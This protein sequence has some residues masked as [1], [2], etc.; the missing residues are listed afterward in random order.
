MLSYLCEDGGFIH[1]VMWRC[2]RCYLC[3]R[4]VC[5]Q[6][7]LSIYLSLLLFGLASPSQIKY[8][9]HIFI[10]FSSKIQNICFSIF[11]SQIIK[12]IQI[13]RLKGDWEASEWTSQRMKKK[14]NNEKTKKVT[15]KIYTKLFMCTLGS[16][17]TIFAAIYYFQRYAIL[18]SVTNRP[19]QTMANNNKNNNNNHHKNKN[20]IQFGHPH[21]VSLSFI[22]PFVVRSPIIV[23]LICVHYKH[24][25]LQMLEKVSKT[26]FRKDYESRHPL[27]MPK[28][29]NDGQKHW[30]SFPL[31]YFFFPP[32][33][34][35]SLPLST[36]CV[37]A[38]VN[39]YA[40][41]QM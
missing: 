6:H 41:A 9:I 3:S 37:P 32:S 2:P 17:H 24:I 14:W 7:H 22:H 19:D 4:S 11:L 30:F 1:A 15:V 8:K 26:Q 35:P 16:R 38:F 23:C 21:S 18:S 29:R 39:V 12:C 31:R 13:Q 5:H 27:H 33:S 40:C 20:S 10:F 36:N 28:L 25:N 34:P